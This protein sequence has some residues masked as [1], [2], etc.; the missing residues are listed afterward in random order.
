MKLN[1]LLQ[2]F[3]LTLLFAG[4]AHAKHILGGNMSF[5]Y[6]GDVL[7]VKLTLFRDCVG[8]GAPFDDPAQIAVYQGVSETSTSLFSSFLAN[9][10]SS[11][12]LTFDNQSCFFPANDICVQMGVYDFVLNLP[13]NSTD[14]YYVVYQR[15]C[16]SVD[17]VNILSPDQVGT[18]IMVA[19]SPLARQLKKSSPQFNQ[20][21]QM[22]ACVHQPVTLNFHADQAEVDSIGYS[23]C[24]PLKGGGSTTM[25]PGLT[26][27]DGVQP[28]PPCS[29]PYGLVSYVV[30]TYL[31][32][33]PFGSDTTYHFN[34]KNG[35]LSLVPPTVGKFIYSVCMEQYH[36]NQLISNTQ[37]V[38]VLY[39]RDGSTSTTEAAGKPEISCIPNPVQETVRLDLTAFSGQNVF[40]TIS[41]LSGRMVA[42]RK[43]QTDGTE[44]F[45]TNK[46][47]SGLYSVLVSSENQI[48]RSRFIHL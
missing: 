17:V 19:I 24:T 30:P 42:I 2:A 15:C 4:Q 9:L 41:D 39:V 22:V 31:P 29:P 20:I 21:P 6:E 3:F 43:I 18:T 27:C 47:P 25:G 11:Q 32:Q 26:G 10:T 48:S 1:R 7:H 16:W 34:A 36:A 14:T 13:Q 40:I 23:M 46:W 8:G 44:F 28:T 45:E 33:E 12:N 37:Q 5:R 38:F 35:S